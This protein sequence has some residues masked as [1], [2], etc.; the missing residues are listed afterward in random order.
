MEPNTLNMLVILLWCE[1]SFW[2]FYCGVILVPGC[3]T[4]GDLSSWLFYCGVILVPGCFIVGR[5]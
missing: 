1:L 3:F 5:S 2:L 4:V